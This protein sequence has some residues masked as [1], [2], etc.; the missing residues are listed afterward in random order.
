MG[1]ENTKPIRMQMIEATNLKK[2]GNKG[3][4]RALLKKPSLS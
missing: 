1:L 2:K 4:P 3:D